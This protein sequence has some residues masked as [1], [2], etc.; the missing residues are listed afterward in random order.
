[1]VRLVSLVLPALVLAPGL[2]GCSAGGVP[3]LADPN[4][5]PFDA[6]NAA[7]RL[8][9]GMPEDVAI[10]RIGWQPIW[11]EVH[12][13]GTLGGYQWTCE[14]LAFGFFDNNRLYVYF[15]LTS[16]AKIVNNWEIHKP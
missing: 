1:M 11:S 4:P 6:A 9:T 7:L 8:A 3:A 15:D 2:A 14:K 10:L 12:T 16:G 13:C 5:P